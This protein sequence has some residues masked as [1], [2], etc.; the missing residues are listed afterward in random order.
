MF[1]YKRLLSIYFVPGT[2]LDIRDTMMSEKCI[3]PAFFQTIPERQA[4]NQISTPGYN[5]KLWLSPMEKKS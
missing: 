5:V 4:E 2:V 1:A 3:D